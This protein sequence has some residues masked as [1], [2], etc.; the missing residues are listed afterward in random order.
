MNV[1]IVISLDICS[2]PRS[3]FCFGCG[4]QGV[5]RPKCPK[6]SGN[7]K[8]GSATLDDATTPVQGPAQAGAPAQSSLDRRK[9][10]QKGKPQQKLKSISPLENPNPSVLYEEPCKMA[11]PMFVTKPGDERPY[12]D[13]Q[14]LGEPLIALADSGSSISILGN[15]EVE[16]ETFLDYSLQVTTA[17]G[18]P[19]A[20]IGNFIVPITLGNM[21]KDVQI[22]V[23]PSINYSLVLVI[24]PT[25]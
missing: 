15:L 12:L 16:C 3:V 13:V 7:G 6:C 24:L 18:V 4:S 19:Q 14:I 2:S 11:C 5:I 8:G 20:S 10:S 23:I 17:D 21:T 25:F 1:G 22:W 9:K